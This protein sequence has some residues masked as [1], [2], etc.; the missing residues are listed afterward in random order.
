MRILPFLVAPIV[1]TATVPSVAAVPELIDRI[2]A[3]V[4][5]QV[6]LWSELNYRLRF[7]LERQGFTSSP[8]EEMLDSL[9]SRVLDEM[10]DEQ[11]LVL[12]ARVDSV[13]IDATRV[14]EMLADQL[15]RI[16]GSMAEDDYKQMLQRVGL[17]ERQLKARYRKEIRHR[18]LYRQM[19]AQQARRQHITRRD[20]QAFR[21]AYQDTL[22]EQISISHIQL[23]VRP[24]EEVLEQKLAE[25]EK[26]QGRL[27]AGEEFAQLAREYSDDQGTASQGGDLGC[28]S[29]GQLVPEFEEVAFQLKPG[30]ISDPVLTQ[31]GY[32]LILLR[33]KREDTIC[34]SHILKLARST[35]ADRERVLEELRRLRQRALAGENFA[36]LAREH[37]Q[38]A[39]TAVRGGLWDIFARDELPPFLAPHVSDLSLGDVS[40][41]FFLRDA[42]DLTGG[43][44][45]KIN[46]DQAT[47]ED[48]I[49][50]QRT[51]AAISELIQDYR[52]KIYIEKRLDE[53][54]LLAPSDHALGLVP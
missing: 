49:R 47:I 45:V 14:E 8:E 13:Q 20:I 22:P 53:P 7:E 5:N 10:I 43:H 46:D 30:E 52:K 27:E 51:A 19:L 26:V 2:V 54:H 41:P 17:S 34:A 23:K 4:D 35:A 29:R 33:D 40:E 12:K 18:L 6:I 1:L 11:V 50:E 24:S 42:G 32:H 25:L 39:G 31:Y 21:T 9:R 15:R 28:F 38:H 37:S 48:L 3:V 36:Q 44:I 16:K